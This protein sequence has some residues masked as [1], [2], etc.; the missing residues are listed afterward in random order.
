MVIDLWTFF[1]CSTG[2]YE[3]NRNGEGKMAWV[4]LYSLLLTSFSIPK[5]SF[6]PLAVK[7][8]V[9]VYIANSTL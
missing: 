8:V 3:G 6:I 4:R 5:L 9:Y 1:I 2:V 7:C